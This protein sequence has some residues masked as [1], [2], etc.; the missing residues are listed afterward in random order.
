MMIER[1]AFDSQLGEFQSEQEPLRATRA[2]G[3]KLWPNWEK[4]LA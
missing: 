3:R 1:P 2:R 4:E